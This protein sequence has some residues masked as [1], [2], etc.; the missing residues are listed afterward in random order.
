MSKKFKRSET[1]FGFSTHA[2]DAD[3]CH[4]RGEPHSNAFLQFV[5]RTRASR[6][7]RIHSCGYASNS[8]LFDAVLRSRST[9]LFPADGKNSPAGVSSPEAQIGLLPT[10]RC[11]GNYFF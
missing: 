2:E 6:K 3:R 5:T 4:L 1:D 11:K 9:N 8:S 10:C 7:I